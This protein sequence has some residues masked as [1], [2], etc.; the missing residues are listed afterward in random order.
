MSDFLTPSSAFLQK[1][2]KAVEQNMADENYGVSQLAEQ[3][4]MS[5]SNL[6]RKIKKETALSGS[7]YIRQI[8]LFHAQKLLKNDAF[9]VS[10]VFF[11]VGFSSTSYFTKCFRELFGFT[12]GSA[13]KRYI[14]KPNNAF[15]HG[16]TNA[17]PYRK[18]YTVLILGSIGVML[19]G[20]IA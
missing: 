4:N 16:G 18:F 1:V 17:E 3:V 7:V 10:E 12:P 2:I 20:T 15:N 13:E 6:L 5:R 11:K 8:R 9:S 14:S 19:L